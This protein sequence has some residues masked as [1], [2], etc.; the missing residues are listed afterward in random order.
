MRWS[1]FGPRDVLDQKY[2]EKFGPL[3]PV[4]SYKQ[5]P[6]ALPDEGYVLLERTFNQLKITR[7]DGS[8]VLLKWDGSDTFKRFVHNEGVPFEKMEKILDHTWSFRASYVNTAVEPFVMFPEL[9][10]TAQW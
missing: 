7:P 9:L 8:F 3:S 6:A 10:D 4:E 5:P 2:N 1:P